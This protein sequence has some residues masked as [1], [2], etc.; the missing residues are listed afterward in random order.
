MML[1]VVVAGAVLGALLPRAKNAL[2]AQYNVLVAPELREI[3]CNGDSLRLTITVTDSANGTPISGAS[4]QIVMTDTGATASLGGTS[5]PSVSGQTNS[6]GVLRARLTPAP[7]TK[8]SFHYVVGVAGGPAP[9][10]TAGA[11]PFSDDTSYTVSGD[12]F[13]DSNG[14]GT[15][16]RREGPASLQ[17]V[18]IYALCENGGCV[19][20]VHTERSDFRGH[21]RFTGLSEGTDVRCCLSTGEAYTT[22]TYFLCVPDQWHQTIVSLN[23]APLPDGSV[24]HVTSLDGHPIT[25]SQCVY[26]DILQAG[27]NHYSIGLGW[28]H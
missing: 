8:A 25:P 2:A 21:F 1:L 23:G 15:R 19:V 28:R 6:H 27:D 12:A 26:A 18:E 16:D 11:C 9:H 17:K 7:G 20:P 10:V 4:I 14:N 3:R 24:Q 13:H 5:G 22:P